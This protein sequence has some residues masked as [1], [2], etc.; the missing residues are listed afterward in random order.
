MPDAISKLSWRKWKA[1]LIVA[2]F[3]GLIDALAV[4]WADPDILYKHQVL[5]LLL[6]YWT[7]KNMG[8]Y[9]KSHPVEEVDDK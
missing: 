5:L 3:F 8:L 4:I 9:L 1:G 7:A 2:A 6:A